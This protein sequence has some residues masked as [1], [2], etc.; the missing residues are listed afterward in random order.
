MIVKPIL[1]MAAAALGGCTLIDQNTFHPGASQ[2]ATFPPKPKPVVPPAMP[3]GPKPL[4]TI[5]PGARPADYASV[6]HKAVND[7]RARK[8]DVTFDVV[9]M[10]PPDVATDILLGAGAAEVA[11]SIVAEGIAPA[12]VRLAARPDASAIPKEVRVYVR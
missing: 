7:A 2:V 5:S 8:A 12:R 9:E 4:L 3:S 10:E 1:L 11:R 6:L